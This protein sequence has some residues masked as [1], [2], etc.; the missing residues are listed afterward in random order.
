MEKCKGDKKWS[1]LKNIM[2]QNFRI[3]ETTFDVLKWS[4]FE[5]SHLSHLCIPPFQKI[6]KFP[7]NILII[8]SKIDILQLKTY[9]LQ[10]LEYSGHALGICICRCS[11][12]YK[13]ELWVSKSAGAH[14]TKSLKI[15]G[16]KRWCTKDLRVLCTRC[17]R[18]NAF[19]EY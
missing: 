4:E 15:S 16:C 14:S 5:F 6:S 11:L 7:L 17:T 9:Y 18:S 10:L 19:P 3:I 8:T 12:F 13:R 2:V 1:H